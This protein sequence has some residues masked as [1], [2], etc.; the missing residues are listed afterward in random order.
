MSLI[1]VSYGYVVSHMSHVSYKMSRF[2]YVRGM[3][4]ANESCHAQMSHVTYE[5]GMSRECAM[6]HIN[7]SCHIWMSHFT[8]R[9]H[10]TYV[11]HS[12]VTWRIHMWHDAFICDMTHSYVTWLI[13]M[14]HDS[15]TQPWHMMHHFTYARG[16]VMSH[17]NESCHTRMSH[18]THEWVMSHM[19]ET[20]YIHTHTHTHIHTGVCAATHTHTHVTR[21]RQWSRGTRKLYDLY[22]IHLL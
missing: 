11:T 3:S 7:E 22:H 1:Y 18:V 13:H 9:S 16:S 20:R 17:T 8:W 19:N 12:Y 21:H 6:S 15:F 14:W 2:T 4:H 10:V 5:R